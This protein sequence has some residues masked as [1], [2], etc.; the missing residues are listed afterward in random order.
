MI[1][2]I[3]IATATSPNDIQGFKNIC[4]IIRESIDTDFRDVKL[5][6][7]V[8]WVKGYGCTNLAFEL[9]GTDKA[10]ESYANKITMSFMPAKWSTTLD[11]IPDTDTCTLFD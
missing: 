3:L 10:I 9:S 5:E 7:G 8:Y 6:S 2:K 4:D 1:M 11:A